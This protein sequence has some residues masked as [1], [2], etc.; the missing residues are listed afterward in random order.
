MKETKYTHNSGSDGLELSALRMEPDKKEDIK[1][2]LQL[3]YGMCEHKERYIPFMEYM[4][5]HGF[6]TVIHDNRG[7]GG[8][9]RSPEDLGYMYENGAE[10]L[11]E[12]IHEI[13]MDT[14]LY[15]EEELELE[16]LPFTLLGHSMGSLAVRC[17]IQKYDKDI[18]KLIVVGC[19]SKLSGMDAGLAFIKLLEAQKGDHARSKAADKLVMRGEQQEI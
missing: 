14:K 1:G 2:V 17:Y 4:T 8:S 19:P 18:D 11:V 10:A 12:D 3:V 7:H 15:L 9:V 16:D 6:V 5:S 13:T